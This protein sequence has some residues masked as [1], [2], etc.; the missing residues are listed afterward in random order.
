MKK[1]PIRKE[2]TEK[3]IPLIYRK[4]TLHVSRLVTGSM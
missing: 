3:E 2:D 1:E 4:I